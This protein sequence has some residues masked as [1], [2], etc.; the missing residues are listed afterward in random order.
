MYC[1]NRN[2][3]GFT[4][5]EV[6]FS[7]AILGMVTSIT[8]MSFSSA[9]RAWRRATA[10]SENLHHADFV[11]DQLVMGLRSAYYPDEGGD[12]QGYG[13]VH[14]DDGDGPYARDTI[15]WVKLGRSL[16][17]SDARFAE[18][19]HRVRFFVEDTAG[20]AGAAAVTAWQLIGQADDFDPDTLEPLHLSR[21][22]TGFTVRSAYETDTADAIDWLD[23]WE[24]T[25]QIPRVV[26]VTLYLQPLEDGE[27]PLP[28]SRVIEIPAGALSWQR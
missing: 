18:S 8:V 23:E 5:I 22:I 17:E 7:V 11:L 26:A 24:H 15:S 19:P 10:L 2:K 20:G 14:E 28:M 12:V 13:F 27:E 6:L 9:V 21:R 4:L 16:I 3:T 1:I 25:N